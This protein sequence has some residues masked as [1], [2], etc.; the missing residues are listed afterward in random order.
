MCIFM[1]MHVWPAPPKLTT[2]PEARPP[3]QL[4]IKFI[5]DISCISNRR[6]PCGR[7]LYTLRAEGEKNKK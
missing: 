6:S 5:C 1:H 2:H 4:N 7:T 3:R